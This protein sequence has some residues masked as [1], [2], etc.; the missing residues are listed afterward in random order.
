[1]VRSWQDDFIGE[2]QVPDTD[3]LEEKL[4]VNYYYYK[5]NY[6]L[7]ACFMNLYVW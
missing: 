6:L 1:M 7:I 4:R 3:E 5:N 2:F